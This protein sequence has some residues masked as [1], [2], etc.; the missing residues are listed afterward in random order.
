MSRASL[1]PTGRAFPGSEMGGGKEENPK[2]RQ[3]LLLGY[4]MHQPW[5]SAAPAPPLHLIPL[6]LTNLR[7]AARASLPYA[8]GDATSTSRIQTR[9][10]AESLGISRTFA[11][12][13]DH[14][15]DTQLHLAIPREVGVDPNWTKWE[16]TCWIRERLTSLR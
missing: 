12:A 6:L 15:D 4:Q 1:I 3:L 11:Y 16:S 9:A 14:M 8:A 2:P 7:A 5:P 10:V 13:I